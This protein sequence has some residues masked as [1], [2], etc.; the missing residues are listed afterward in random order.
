MAPVAKCDPKFCSLANCFANRPKHQ[1]GRSAWVGQTDLSKIELYS[2]AIIGYNEFMG[3]LTINIYVLLCSG[4]QSCRYLFTLMYIMLSG[5]KFTG[6]PI[7]TLDPMNI[8]HLEIYSLIMWSGKKA[9]HL[10]LLSICQRNGETG[11]LWTR[12]N[13]QKHPPKRA[14]SH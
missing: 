13:S 6:L 9:S 7:L 8:V 14:E 4:K 2:F 5:I 10:D 11:R 1:R 12:G 3:S